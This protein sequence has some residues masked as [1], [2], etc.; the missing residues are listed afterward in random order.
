[1]VNVLSPV[2]LSSAVRVS[3]VNVSSSVLWGGRVWRRCRVSYVQLILAYIWARPVI[4][5]A[6]NSRGKKF[7]FLL[8]FLFVFFLF[9]FFFFFKF[10]SCPSFFPVHF[11]LFLY[12]L[13]YIFSHFLLETTKNDPQGLRCR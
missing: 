9:C 5:V 3:A 2:Q 11:F 13:F 1:M 10:K 7:I 12:Y 4:L 8:F 6:G